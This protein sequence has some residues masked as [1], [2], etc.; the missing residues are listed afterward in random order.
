MYFSLYDDWSH[1]RFNSKEN[2]KHHGWNRD[3]RAIS[4][5]KFFARESADEVTNGH[6]KHPRRPTQITP[7]NHFFQTIPSTSQVCPTWMKVT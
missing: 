7:R 1:D 2:N 4:G 3:A 6:Q 5:I